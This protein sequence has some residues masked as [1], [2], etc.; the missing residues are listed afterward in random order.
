MVSYVLASSLMSPILT[1]RRA[2][3]VLELPLLRCGLEV[4]QHPV[5]LL[6]RL[7]PSS[8]RLRRPLPYPGCLRTHPPTRQLLVGT[9]KRPPLLPPNLGGRSRR[10]CIATM[11]IRTASSKPDLPIDPTVSL[12]FAARGPLCNV[13]AVSTLIASS[14][15]LAPSNSARAALSRVISNSIS[16]HMARW[17]FS[18]LSMK[19]SVV[20]IFRKIEAGAF[21]FFCCCLTSDSN[22]STA[23]SHPPGSFAAT[24]ALSKQSALS[25]TISAEAQDA[26]AGGFSPSCHQV[27]VRALMALLAS[28]LDSSG[29]NGT[30][31]VPSN[32]DNCTSCMS[33]WVDIVAVAIVATQ[34]MNA[35][36]RPP[37]RFFR[38]S[39]PDAMTY[40]LDIQALMQAL[41]Q[42]LIIVSTDLI[43]PLTQRQKL[44]ANKTP[45][46]PRPNKRQRKRQKLP[47]QPQRQRPKTTAT[48]KQKQKHTPKKSSLNNATREQRRR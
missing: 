36:A 27:G 17:R 1:N 19:P 32:F 8:P 26:N 44:S 11:S 42:A 7:L 9:S 4:S 12:T 48:P 39:V 21:A 6:G 38:L 37:M 5:Q 18:A 13:S 33:M 31:C 47:P 23:E 10:E 24:I 29:N 30:L 22:D 15:V 25:C 14:R 34:I 46:P 43:A 41:I 3:V 16:S 40:L 20:S 28:P 2:T 45:T 35:K